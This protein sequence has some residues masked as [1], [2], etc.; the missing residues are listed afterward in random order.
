MPEFL[1][2]IRIDHLEEGEY[3]ATSDEL[4]ELLAQGRT[5]AA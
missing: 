3:L 5:V 4:P 1:L 2:P